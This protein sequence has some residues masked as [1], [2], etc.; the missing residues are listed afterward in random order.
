MPENYYLLNI[1]HVISKDE[2]TPK[3]LPF[4]PDSLKSSLN[5][6]P[7]RGRKDREA[8]GLEISI[9]EVNLF[10]R[11]G[12]VTVLAGIDRG[13]TDRAGRQFS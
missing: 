12:C 3:N 1:P 13:G 4:L 6:L 5:R 10:Q 2:R 11:L 7:A 9:K 8:S